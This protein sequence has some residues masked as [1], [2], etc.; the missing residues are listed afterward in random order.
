MNNKHQIS[1]LP[2]S[3]ALNLETA[4]Y[5]NL[6]FP[7]VQLVNIVFQKTRMVLSNPQSFKALLVMMM[8]LSMKFGW[9]HLLSENSI[10][11]NSVLGNYQTW[12]K[13]ASFNFKTNLELGK[14]FTEH[15]NQKVWINK[16]FEIVIVFCIFSILSAMTKIL[17][18]KIN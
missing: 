12:L 14:K 18:S 9:S 2:R 11:I 16:L 6:S 3:K 8:D 7:K 10:Q 13:K 15:V 5:I 4:E 17:Y 1:D